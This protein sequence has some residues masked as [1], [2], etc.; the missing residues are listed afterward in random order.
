MAHSYSSWST[1]EKCPAKYKYSYIDKLPRS[2]PGPAAAR[3][4]EI[5]NAVETVLRGGEPAGGTP[6]PAGYKN[7]LRGLTEYTLHPELK[8]SVGEDWQPVPYAEAVWRGYMDLLIAPEEGENVLN[9]YEWK[10]GKVYPEHAHQAELYA[11]VGHSLYPEV[12][13]VMVT[14]VYFDQGKSVEREYE[15]AHVE[16]IQAVW[17][18]RRKNVERDDIH[19]A[20]PGFYCRFC[21]YAKDKGGPCLF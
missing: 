15:A 7:W 20:N 17:N 16:G 19:P 18:R 12:A 13:T 5:H 2:P 8:W 3:G 21:D 11:L 6:T 4:T 10:T 1:H 14:N 9:I